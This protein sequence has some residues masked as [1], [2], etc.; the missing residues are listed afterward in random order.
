[1]W[2]CRWDQLKSD[3]TDTAHGM[4]ICIFTFNMKVMK[5]KV[6]RTSWVRKICV[7]LTSWKRGLV[8]FFLKNVCTSMDWN[9]MLSVFLRKD[10]ALLCLLVTS[11]PC[12][13]TSAGD[14]TSLHRHPHPHVAC[15]CPVITQTQHNDLDSGVSMPPHTH[16]VEDK[17]D[18]RG[19]YN[20]TQEK[21]AMMTVLID[22][23]L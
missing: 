14:N 6:I 18:G 8:S 12:P 4:F 13:E 2:S 19:S 3:F 10:I 7:P 5:L 22:F 17:P 16:A 20:S 15:E 1:M 11:G 23:Y 9:T 21:T